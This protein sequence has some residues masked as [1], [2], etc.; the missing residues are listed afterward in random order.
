MNFPILSAITFIPLLLAVIV[1]MI[2]KSKLNLIRWTST[3]LSLIPLGTR[4][5]VDAG[6][7]LKV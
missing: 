7:E 2:P 4:P 5:P 1:L 6:V 3:V